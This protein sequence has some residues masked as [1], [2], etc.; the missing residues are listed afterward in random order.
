MYHFFWGWMNKKFGDGQC[1]CHQGAW[2]LTHTHRQTHNAFETSAAVCGVIVCHSTHY[3]LL[4]SAK[5]FSSL[6]FTH[7]S[8]LS[9]FHSHAFLFPSIQKTKRC[10]N[11]TEIW[12]TLA[13]FRETRANVLWRILNLDMWSSTDCE[14]ENSSPHL[15][16]HRDPDPNTELIEPVN[17]SAPYHHA[18]KGFLDA[19]VFFTE[20]SGSSH[21]KTWGQ[22][23]TVP[24]IKNTRR[25]LHS[26]SYWNTLTECTL[27]TFV[28][29]SKLS[30]HWNFWCSAV[31]EHF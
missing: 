20:V 10:C 6:P 12:L 9:L 1:I 19:N 22:K 25:K 18:T 13:A 17:A 26:F 3:M 8:S 4:F 27:Q 15:I 30:G 28:S 24:F 5:T 21:G 7:S 2:V 14:G 31:H 23:K 29:A 16:R 11:F